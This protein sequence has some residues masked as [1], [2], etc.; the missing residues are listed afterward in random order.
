MHLAVSKGFIYGKTSKISDLG[1][2]EKLLNFY[3]IEKVLSFECEVFFT[4]YQNI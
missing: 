1:G 2:K 4:S 3:F